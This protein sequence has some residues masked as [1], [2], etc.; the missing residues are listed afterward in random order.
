MTQPPV[1]P[2]S[3][4]PPGGY[5]PPAPTVAL[6][7]GSYTSWITRVAAYVIDA[8]PVAVLTG[9]GQ[10]LMLVTANGENDC[11]KGRVRVDNGDSGYAYVCGPQP[12]GLGLTLA[13]VFALAAVA[14][15]IWNY[16][17]RQGTT[18]SSIGKWVMKFKVVGEA[19]GQPIGFGL[20][21][22]RQ[23]AHILDSILC[24]IGYLWP[25]WDAKRQT[26]ADKIMST[27]CLPT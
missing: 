15:A 6:P 2:G 11:V 8:V 4:P 19:T 25:L 23:L 17:Y 22:V 21:V 7:K 16:G 5:Y 14:F 12:S 26:F 27:V 3:V 1:P 20:S 13:F 9:I 10:V 24:S 18:G